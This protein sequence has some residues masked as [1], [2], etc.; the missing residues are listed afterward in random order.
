MGWSNKTRRKMF[1]CDFFSHC[2]IHNA[3]FRRTKP[4]TCKICVN[5]LVRVLSI[6]LTQ[7]L[8]VLC[9]HIE[10]YKN[11]ITLITTIRRRKRLATRERNLLAT[12]L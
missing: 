11:L 6:R 7:M 3:D 1:N 5:L 2:G 9:I 12:T 8:L 4:H 10:V